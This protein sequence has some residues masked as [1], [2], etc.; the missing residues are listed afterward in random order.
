MNMNRLTIVVTGATD[1]IGR[2]TARALAR[3]GADVVVHGRS[4]AKVE[5]VVAELR[6]L[7]GRAPPAPLIADL[8]SLE[9]IRAAGRAFVSR[10]RPLDV[11]VNNAGVFMT[12]RQL[13]PDGHEL[14]FAVN[15][16]A[17]FLL[18]HLL[19]EA[20]VAAPRGRVVHVSSMAHARGRIDFDDLDFVRGFSGLRAYATTKLMN[21]LFSNEL[22]RRLRASARSAQVT[23]NALHPGVVTTKLLREGF[24]MNGHDSLDEGAATSVHLAVSPDVDGVTGAYFARNSPTRPA[25]VVNDVDALRLYELS[26]TLTSVAPL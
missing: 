22:A 24:G 10:G 9:D 19:M 16:L 1:G 3:H 2:S 15:H 13:S 5:A 17:P 7:T 8:A 11:L 25:S 20:L 21:V 26:T 18:T 14:S 4:A 6:D 12:Q 23:S